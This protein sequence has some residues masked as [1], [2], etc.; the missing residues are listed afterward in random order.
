MNDQVGWR[1]LLRRLEK[2]AP[3]Y[4]QYLPELPRLVHDALQRPASS[5]AEQELMKAL[6]IEQRRTN[7][8]LQVIVW[9]TLGFAAG[10][11]GMQLLLRLIHA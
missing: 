10:A 7:R 9:G 11:V 5:P 4:A 2:E 8:L 6:L 3:R 1:G